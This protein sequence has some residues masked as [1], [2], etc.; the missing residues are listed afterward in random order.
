[1]S[2]SMLGEDPQ[3][4]ARA[5]TAALQDMTKQLA[6]VKATVR[7]GKR[8]IAALVISLVLDV[9]LTVGVSIA[10]VQASDASGKASATITQLHA[11]NVSACRKANVNRAEDV[12]IWNQFLADLAPPAARTAKVRAELAGINRLIRIKDTLRNC[13]AAYKL[14]TAAAA[15]YGP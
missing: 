4:T 6:G 1:M 15:Q 5:L 11:S 8:V 7:R 3:E 13:A 2:G 9:A 12:A 14:G 10:A